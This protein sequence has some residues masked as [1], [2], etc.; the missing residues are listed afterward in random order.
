MGNKK[1]KRGSTSIITTIERTPDNDYGVMSDPDEI[2]SPI[3]SPSPSSAS[4]MSPLPL[5]LLMPELPELPATT[6]TT[7]ATTAATTTTTTTTTTATATAATT[8]LD[9]YSH[10]HTEPSHSP[11]LQP[12]RQPSSQPS[13]PQ[14]SPSLEPQ[15]S[16]S[17][18][19]QQQ[20]PSKSLAALQLKLSRDKN[21]SKKITLHTFFSY[22][23]LA[24]E[25][26]RASSASIA[27]ISPFAVQDLI[28]YM[29][30][31]HTETEATRI[32]LHTLI[33]TGVIKCLIESIIEFNKDQTEAFNK[34]LTEEQIELE[35]ISIQESTR[36]SS[37][38]AA[39]AATDPSRATQTPQDSESMV[40]RIRNFFKRCFVCCQCRRQGC[41]ND[42]KKIYE[43]KA[44]NC[45]TTT[46]HQEVS[47]GD[48]SHPR[49]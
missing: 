8:T 38:A 42:E 11:P 25:M 44:V 17:Q 23:I 41:R 21:F 12:S 4:S 37:S 1:N 40:T 46:D 14:Q 30:E 7:T 27:R 28:E 47:N 16:S 39:A 15:K 13:S 45:E 5:P 43:P 22:V 35:M 34:L 2:V 36:Q 31:H 26:E 32:Y 18:Q 33:D 9:E 6:T 10:N 29:I 19:Q 49:K 3:I 48:Q 24:M 20:P